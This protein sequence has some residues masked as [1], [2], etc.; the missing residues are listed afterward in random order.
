MVKA[1][2]SSVVGVHPSAMSEIVTAAV[3]GTSFSVTLWYPGASVRVAVS[4][5]S[6]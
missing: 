4:F 1:C 5:P 6:T 2:V 3:S